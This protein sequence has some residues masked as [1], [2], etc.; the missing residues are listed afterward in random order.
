MSPLLQEL[1]EHRPRATTKIQDPAAPTHK[2]VHRHFQ[3]S[4]EHLDIA[5]VFRG[6]LMLFVPFLLFIQRKVMGFFHLN[7]LAV[8]TIKVGTLIPGGEEYFSGIL[9]NRTEIRSQVL[10]RWSKVLNIGLIP[11]LTVNPL[12]LI[13]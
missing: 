6:V 5:L 1:R 10:L 2:R 13:G 11:I 7:E 9:A 4:L 3:E 8:R 12:M